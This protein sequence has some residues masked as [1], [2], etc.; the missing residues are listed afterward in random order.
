MERGGRRAFPL[1]LFKK[2]PLHPPLPAPPVL[3]SSLP[4]SSPPPLPARGSG[5]RCKLPQRGPR[6]CPGRQRIL[7]LFVSREAENAFGDNGFSNP[8]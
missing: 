8:T 6:Q 1:F 5:K 3:L 4:S 2:R 7:D